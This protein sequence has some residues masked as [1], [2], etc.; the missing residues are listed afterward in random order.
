MNRQFT[1]TRLVLAIISMA[2]EQV[3]IWAVWQWLLPAF[4][5]QLHVG[6]LIGVMVGWGIIGTCIFIFT[7]SILKKQKSV[8][9]TSMVGA[10]GKAAGNLAPGGMVK[11]HGEL[12]SAISEEGDII[13]GE[14]I[15]VTGEKGLK[16]LVRK[17]I[18]G[19][20]H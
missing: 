18:A 2:L 3:G 12:W 1:L 20:R 9:Q 8:G 10:T 16:L 11:I 4:G 6:V 19:A 13:I 14:D 17:N 7:T 15:V 5:I